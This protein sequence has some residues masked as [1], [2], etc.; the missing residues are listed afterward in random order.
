MEAPPVPAQALEESE[1]AVDWGGEPEQATAVAGSSA[2]ASGKPVSE[3][4]PEAGSTFL[5]SS[6]DSFQEHGGSD[7][8]GEGDS[9]TENGT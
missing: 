2:E 1:N 9:S 5:C 8:E 3:L 6:V 7:I 4:A